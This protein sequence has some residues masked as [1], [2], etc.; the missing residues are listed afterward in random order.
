[1]SLLRVIYL[2]LGILVAIPLSAG[3]D[4]SSLAIEDFAKREKAQKSIEDWLSKSP[5]KHLQTLVRRYEKEEDPEVRARIGDLLRKVFNRK[6]GFM[7]ISMAQLGRGM[8]PRPVLGVNVGEVHADTAAQ[9]AGLLM[10]DLIIE[11]GG[12]RLE[13]QNVNDANEA[14]SRKV[15]SYFAGDTIEVKIVRGQETLTKKMT[16]MAM[17]AHLDRQPPVGKEQQEKNFEAWRKG[18]LENK[19]K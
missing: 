18:I 2:I 3:P 19:K 16:L 8:R 7:G 1:V 10:G 5:E 6:P 11:I 12:E 4:F 9:A 13:R 17:P 14:L 15:K